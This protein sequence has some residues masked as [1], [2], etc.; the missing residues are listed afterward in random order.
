[1][2]VAPLRTNFNFNLEALRG[3]AA[4]TVAWHHAIYH[5]RHLDP[6]Y[7]P[8]GAWA[9]NPPGHLAVLI[10]F[11]LS[12]YVIGRR[13]PRPLRGSEIKDY[14]HRRLVRVYPMYVLAV[15]AGVL[16]SGFSISW[17]MVVYHLLFWQSWGEP[18][19]FE[20]NPLWSLQ[21][22]VLYYLAFIPLSGLGL[23]PWVVAALAGL[24]G[25]GAL[26]LGP[27][28]WY[29]ALAQYLIGLAFWALGW[30]LAAV[31]PATAVAWPRVLSALLLLLS[32]ELLNPLTA[33]L[34]ELNAWLGA[35]Q[36]TFS[37]GWE[38]PAYAFNTNWG[39]DYG[40]LPYA[41]LIVLQVAGMGGRG[42]R[43]LAGGLQLLPLYGVWQASQHWQAAYAIPCALYGASL[44]F[45]FGP[46]AVLAPASRRVV[47][48]LVPL[49]AISYGIYII[50][51]PI[52]F[53]M[54]K[55]TWFSGSPGTFAG[56]AGLYLVAT[57]LAA[58]WLDKVFQPWAKRLFG[59]VPGP[60]GL[61]AAGETRP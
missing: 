52:L 59:P 1:M 7:V 49:G 17:K 60:A 39:L 55:V 56:R 32:L 2:E 26:L 61:A 42:V 9:F 10:F 38:A 43:W 20:N 47:R 27:D 53:L 25:A 28:E 18:V 16:V 19:M 34:G 46:P 24:A 14:L 40:F 22:E 48:R 21:Y 29:G 58:T 4:L 54:G 44:L 23:R 33:L 15:L 41:A 3:V 31:R 30:A 6:G 8:T 12:G 57:L 35:H 13:Y 51:F 50:H 5:P 45:F 36:L 37:R 11:L